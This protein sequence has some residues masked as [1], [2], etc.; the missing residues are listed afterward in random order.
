V[1]AH[2]LVGIATQTREF[3][4]MHGEVARLDL[5]PETLGNIHQR[6]DAVEDACDRLEMVEEDR[7][8]DEDEDD[9]W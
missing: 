2:A 1:N 6:M 8:G 7:V 3:A 4:G 5:L 9:S